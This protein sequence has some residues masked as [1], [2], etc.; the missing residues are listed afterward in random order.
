[1][2]NRIFSTTDFFKKALDGSALRHNAISNN[3]ANVNTPGYKRVTVEFEDLL[4]NE[5][6]KNRIRLSTTHSKHIGGYTSASIGSVVKEHKNYSTRRDKN[7]VNIDIEVAERAKNEIYYNAISR[8]LS[9]QFEAISSVINE[10][11]R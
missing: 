9:R 4:K 8:Q 3:I 5:L 1:M 10:G 2:V 6:E 11:G 7:S